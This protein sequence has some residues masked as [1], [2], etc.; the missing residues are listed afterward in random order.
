MT[1][2]QLLGACLA[3]LAL[4]ACNEVTVGPS[5]TVASIQVEPAAGAIL[6]AD[7]LRLI[8]A[9]LD[10]DGNQV[11]NHVIEWAT[12]DPSVAT[13]TAG[14]LVRG[15]GAGQVFV[16][17]ASGSEADSATLEVVAPLK[18]NQISAGES[19][20]CAVTAL[21]IGY[22]WGNNYSG[23]LG[24][25]FIAG[26]VT[27]PTAVIG[28]LT[29]TTIDAGGSFSGH[30][31]GL[32]AG[33]AYCWGS[34]GNGQVGD[35]TTTN[36]VM[37]TL[38]QNAPT[39]SAL[40]VGHISSCGIVSTGVWCWP[41]GPY[42]F[43]YSGQPALQ[44]LDFGESHLCGVTAGGIAYCWGYNYSG[45]L[46][47]STTVNRFQPMPVAGG[48]T[49]LSLS[50]TRDFTCGLATG[51]TV[52]CWGNLA[53]FGLG[54]EL[55]PTAVSSGIAFTSISAAGGHVCALT[56]AGDAYCWGYNYNGELGDGTTIAR[57]APVPVLGGLRFTTIDAGSTHTCGIAQSA[58]VY[59][60][61]G[62]YNGQVGDNSIQ[63]RVEPAVVWAP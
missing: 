58:I 51:G 26:S 18:A 44:S 13:V 59:C 62:N 37:P 19:S 50:A 30:S 12:S 61:G 15:I 29:W 4:V 60:W 43:G 22:C 63:D 45:Q 46:G 47:D 24:N 38:V 21:G 14:G 33:T 27:R 40:A 11:I 3:T 8:A 2:H 56:S 5:G 31:C 25:G 41:V 39:F 28:G 52:Y 9:T 35:G 49:F 32:A 6:V 7:T 42:S 34:N 54:Q 36:R 55:V 57:A 16:F 10:E 17:A 53:P 23:N 20:T 48:R 1:K